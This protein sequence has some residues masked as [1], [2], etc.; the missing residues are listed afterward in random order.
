MK[1]F[2]LIL[3]VAV[4]LCWSSVCYADIDVDIE[5]ESL[6]RFMTTFIST[7]KTRI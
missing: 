4:T 5:G 2:I 3:C 6:N 1:K 7:E